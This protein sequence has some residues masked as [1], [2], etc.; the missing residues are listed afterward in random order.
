MRRYSPSF[1]SRYIKIPD[2]ERVLCSE[3]S[4]YLGDSIL[5]VV[6]V[7][8]WFF[9]L[10]KDLIVSEKIF[11]KFQ[12]QVYQDFWSRTSSLLRDLLVLGRLNTD[13]CWSWQV[14]FSTYKVPNRVGEE[15]DQVSTPGISR[16]LI[17]DVFSAQRPPRTWE[18]Q[19]W[20]LLE[21]A[22]GFFNF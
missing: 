15:I 5:I 11:T 4:S 10:I 3:T 6:G 21:L 7:G 14:V 22:G 9:Q 8:R 16:L 13:R 17:Q 19:Y 18:T 20:S 2:P 12:L 1:S